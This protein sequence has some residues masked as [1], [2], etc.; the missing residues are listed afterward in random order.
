MYSLHICSAT[1]ATSTYSLFNICSQMVQKGFSKL[2]RD[3]RLADLTLLI[4]GEKL[5]VHK[6]VLCTWSTL[7]LRR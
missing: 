5:R 1:L 4:G 2:F 6:L 3:K 7:S